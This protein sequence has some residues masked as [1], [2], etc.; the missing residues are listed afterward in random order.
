[1]SDPIIRS[2]KNRKHGSLKG[3]TRKTLRFAED[4]IE[5]IKDQ[6]REHKLSEAAVV[7]MIIRNFAS[8]PE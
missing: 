8:S 4:V 2:R 3:G 1:M 7:E 6:A 5:Y